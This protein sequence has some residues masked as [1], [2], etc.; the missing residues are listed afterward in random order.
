MAQ[1]W[2]STLRPISLHQ[3][4]PPSH[5]WLLKSKTITPGQEAVLSCQDPGTRMRQE[6]RDPEIVEPEQQ[7]R[8]EAEWV[9][10]LGNLQAGW[11]WE[12]T[13]PRYHTVTWGD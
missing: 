2:Q 4:S 8:G 3:L 9:M 6:E 12:A 13:W 5:I 11:P 1:V 7:V 10:D